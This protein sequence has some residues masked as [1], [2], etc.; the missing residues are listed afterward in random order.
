MWELQCVWELQR[1]GVKGYGKSV[2]GSCGVLGVA[3]WGDC[4]VGGCGVGGLQCG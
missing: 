3:I 4:D 2:C 1:V